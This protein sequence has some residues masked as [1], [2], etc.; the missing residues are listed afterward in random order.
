MTHPS[1]PAAATIPA[2]D[3]ER[4]FTLARSDSANLPHIG[5]LFVAATGWT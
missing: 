1:F 5:S 2:D 4:D 3:P